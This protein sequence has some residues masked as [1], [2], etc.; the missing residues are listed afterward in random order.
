M[1]TRELKFD[2]E[3]LWIEDDATAHQEGHEDL[4]TAFKRLTGYDLVELRK[5]KLTSRVHMRYDEDY[6]FIHGSETKNGYERKITNFVL[7]LSYPGNN[8]IYRLLQ[9]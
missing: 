6:E 7:M 4:I 3:R 8:A 5:Q 2:L 9:D 1:T